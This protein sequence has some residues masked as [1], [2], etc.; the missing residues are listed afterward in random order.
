MA[1]SKTRVYYWLFWL[2]V[3]A[4]IATLLNPSAPGFADQPIQYLAPVIFALPY[5]VSQFQSGM[6]SPSA[7]R[8][9]GVGNE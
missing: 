6:S 4:F 1:I 3:I 8:S 7:E 5:V 9:S 2:G